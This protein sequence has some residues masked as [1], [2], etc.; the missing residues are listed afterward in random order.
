LPCSYSL[1][2]KLKN[3]IVAGLALAPTVA[4]ADDLGYVPL[5]DEIQSRAQAAVKLIGE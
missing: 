2:M 5:K 1:F 4:L 3:L